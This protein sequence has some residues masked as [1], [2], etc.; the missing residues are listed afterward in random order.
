MRLP[1][2]I[3]LIILISLVGCEL[4]TTRTPES[5]EDNAVNYPPANILG[6]FAF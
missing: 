5:P 2:K 3:S 1:L 4:F 6:N